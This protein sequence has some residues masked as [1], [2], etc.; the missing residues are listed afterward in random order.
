MPPA[1]YVVVI[2][3]SGQ[4]IAASSYNGTHVAVRARRLPDSR[5]PMRQWQV[6]SAPRAL[7]VCG[8]AY[9][10]IVLRAIFSAIR[11]RRGA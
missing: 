8:D 5:G 9:C 10:C 2:G 6:G 1:I 11:R 3:S 7:T 4:R